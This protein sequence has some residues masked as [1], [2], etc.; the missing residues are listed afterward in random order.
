MQAFKN[1]EIVRSRD[2]KVLD[3]C[4]I[5]IDVGGVYDPAAHRYDHHQKGFTEVFGHGALRAAMAVPGSGAAEQKRMAPPSAQASRPSCLA[6]AS[7][8]STLVRRAS[9][10]I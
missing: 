3:E 10:R 2:P 8:T 5:V 4:D 7:S 6:P 1:A 9:F